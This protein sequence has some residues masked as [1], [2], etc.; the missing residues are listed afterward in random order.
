[1]LAAVCDDRFDQH[2]DLSQVAR[3]THHLSSERK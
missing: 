2:C 1:V 3:S